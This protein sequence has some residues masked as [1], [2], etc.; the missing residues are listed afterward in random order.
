VDYVYVAASKNNPGQIN[1]YLADSLS[2]A[3]TQ[4]QE[5]PY[6][7]GGRNPVAM[8]TSPNGKYLYV[9]NK[10]DNNIVQFAIG[11]DAK[12]YPQQTCN[13]PGSAPLAIA[14]NQ[15]GTFLYVVDQYS[16]QYPGGPVYSSSNPGP[17]DVVVYPLNSNQAL[18]GCTPVTQTFV[19]SSN[20]TQTATYVPVGMNPTGVSALANGNYVYVS[21]QNSASSLGEVYAFNVASGGTLSNVAGSPFQ[22]GTSPSSLIA[23]TSQNGTYLYVTDSLQNQL[24]TFT[25]LSTGALSPNPNGPTKTDTLPFNITVDPRGQYLYVANYNANDISAYAIGSNGTPSA[26]A[27]AGTYATGAGPF[28]VLVEPALGRFVYTANFIDNTV[29]GFELN[30]N[31]GALTST[32][33]SPYSASG[34]PTCAAAIPHGNHSLQNVQSTAG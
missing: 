7:S 4:I 8:V 31:T 14:V 24:I 27:G 21:A 6:P 11:T 22:A 23:V 28:C 34:Q 25:I 2:G 33:N 30:P 20:T 16:P 9:V 32:Q 15:S 18:T 13:T 29:T 10:D 3:L 1:V 5:S 12:I 17:G 19:D 26:V